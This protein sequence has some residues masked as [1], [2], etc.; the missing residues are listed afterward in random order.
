MSGPASTGGKHVF[1]S[2][3]HADSRWLDRLL[4]HLRPLIR[5]GHIRVFSDQDIDIGA[6]WRREIQVALDATSVAVLL[7][8][9][10]F[11]ASDFIMDEEL[12][13]L[14]AAAAS[15]GTTIMPVIVG[16]SLFEQ[17]PSLS[18]FQAANQPGRPLSAMRPAE[19]NN[20]L[21]DVARQI[22]RL[23]T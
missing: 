23:V 12:P 15:R 19:W 8:S 20:V 2:Y 5:N 17:T 13:V 21:L 18:R 14:L 4:Q 3:N 6:D 9:A 11:L 10:N 16:P 22:Q 1:I 7:V